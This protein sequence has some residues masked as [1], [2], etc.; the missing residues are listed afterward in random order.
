MLRCCTAVNAPPGVFPVRIRISP[1]WLTSNTPTPWRTALCSGIKPP[2]AGYSTGISQPPKFTI[3]APSLRCSA[4]NGVLR[5]GVDC[6]AA[7]GEVDCSAAAPEFVVGVVTEFILLSQAEILILAC[8]PKP[9]KEAQSA[10]NAVR[11][12]ETFC[13]FAAP[14]N[15]PKNNT[16]R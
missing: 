16:L 10:S 12:L 9:V 3:L 2:F 14:L 4:F 8:A 13:E 15:L 1:I 5:S 7:T 11:T 6:S